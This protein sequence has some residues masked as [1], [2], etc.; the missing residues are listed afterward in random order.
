MPSPKGQGGRALVCP[1]K[2]YVFYLIQE[3][4]FML[5]ITIF[6]KSF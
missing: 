2:V 4:H 6:A 1:V 5:F 3:K